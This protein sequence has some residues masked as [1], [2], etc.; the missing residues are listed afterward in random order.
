MD[1]VTQQN[2]A[3]VEEAAA[4]AESLQ[5]QSGQLADVVS[6]FKLDGAQAPAARANANARPAAPRA[7]LASAAPKRPAAGPASR[8]AS[9]PTAGRPA[10]HAVPSQRQSA[11]RDDEWEVF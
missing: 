4:A 6:V 7:A 9:R 5:E 8:P 3:L 10:L 11:P 1:Q 2:A